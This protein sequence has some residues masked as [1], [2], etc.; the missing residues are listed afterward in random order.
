[1]FKKK[2]FTLIEL[3]VVIAIL[4]AFAG[5]ITPQVFRQVAKGRRA[6]VIGFYNS[7]KTA[8][9]AHVADTGLWPTAPAPGGFTTAGGVP[10]WDGPYIDRW[11]AGPWATSTYTWTSIAGNVFGSGGVGERYITVTNVLDVNDRN[12]LDTLIDGAINGAAGSC[13]FGTVAP[14]PCSGNTVC[15]AVSR[16]GAIS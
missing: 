3:M 12:E 15:I 13:R 16:D 14:A 1:M 5:V 2:G 6:A 9:N 10:G 8:A 4:A 7:I 11:P